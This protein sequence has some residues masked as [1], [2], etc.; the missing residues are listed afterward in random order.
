MGFIQQGC[1]VLKM[2]IEHVCCVVSVCESSCSEKQPEGSPLSCSGVVLNYQSGLVLCSGLLLSRFLL[3]KECISQNPTILSAHKFSK[4]IKVYID[5]VDVKVN[6]W[7]STSSMRNARPCRQPAELLLMVNC[8]E[9]QTAFQKLFTDSEQWKFSDCDEDNEILYD[10]NFLSWF[11]VLQMTTNTQAEPVPWIKSTA[12][13]KGCSVLACGS[14]FGSFCPDLFMSTLS[15]GIVSNLAGQE[16][17]LILTDARCLPGTQGGGLF[18]CDGDTVY[19]VGLITSPLCW[20]SNEWI[21]L[22]LVCSLHLILK[23]I[24]QA[25]T[26]PQLLIEI[27]TQS[28]TDNPHFPADAL[29]NSENGKYPM[30]VVVECG[31]LWGSG[32]VLNPYLVLTCRHVVNGSQFPKVTFNTSER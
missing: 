16:N 32:I 9:F 14:P 27:S 6:Q 31:Q 18:A 4:K 24:L 2:S 1:Y 25:V 21:G 13:K 5:Y 20:K 30:V 11:A 29:Q 26:F 10:S 12:L 23:N 22:T 8:L 28:F 19:L 3:D 7:T 15:K 17:A